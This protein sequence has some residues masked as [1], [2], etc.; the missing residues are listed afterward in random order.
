MIG[1]LVGFVPPASTGAVLAAIEA[2]D[3][4]LVVGLTL[5]GLFEGAALGAAQATV[6]SRDA[7]AVNRRD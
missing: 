3:P 6:L 2:S 5:A 4:V 1:E 7:P